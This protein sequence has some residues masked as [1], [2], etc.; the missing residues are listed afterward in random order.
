MSER[1][2]V[3]TTTSGSPHPGQ[4]S[5]RG[6][7]RGSRGKPRWNKNRQNKYN[8]TGKTKEMNGHVFQLRVEQK[9]RMPY[10]RNQI[11]MRRME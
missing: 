3:T 10:M 8:F 4:R 5:G 9:K 2:N 11:L 1:T 7:N 6:N